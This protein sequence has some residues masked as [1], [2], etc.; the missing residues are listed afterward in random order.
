MRR[1]NKSNRGRR[2]GGRGAL[3]EDAELADGTSQGKGE[4]IEEM[5][6]AETRAKKMAGGTKEES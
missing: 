5:T 6:E 1:Y 3:E 4:A 2:E